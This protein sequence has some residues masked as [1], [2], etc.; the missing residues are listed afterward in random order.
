MSTRAIA[1]FYFVFSLAILAAAMP[2]GEPPN[3]TKT[4]TVTSPPKTTTV[5]SPPKTSTIT[6]T[7]PASTPTGSTCST[8][9]IQCC[10][11][12]GQVRLLDV[13]IPVTAKLI[14]VYYRPLTPS[15]VSSLGC[16]ALSLTV[17]MSCLV[18]TVPRLASSVLA[19]VLATPTWSVARTTT[20][21]VVE[22]VLHDVFAELIHTLRAGSSPS[23]AFRSSSE[24]WCPGA[25]N[26]FKRVLFTY[27]L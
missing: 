17:S 14:F 20:S 11:Q 25:E 24:C 15:S 26:G 27:S 22:F 8:G 5:T 16:S 13:L 6:V 3:K 12:V 2:G 4:T 10:N 21:Y 9:P 23:A 7:A 18:S 19:A 1:T